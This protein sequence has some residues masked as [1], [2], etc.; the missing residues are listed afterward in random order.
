MT[1]WRGSGHFGG[2]PR[3][4]SG[5]PLLVSSDVCS[6]SDGTPRCRGVHSPAL[7][8]TCVRRLTFASAPVPPGV[9]ITALPGFRARGVS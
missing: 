1:G 4:V 3:V 6:E 8:G 7:R 2:G 5:S 9:A